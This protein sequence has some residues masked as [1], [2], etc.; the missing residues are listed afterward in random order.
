MEMWGVLKYIFKI[1]YLF[2]V[3]VCV[4][5]SMFSTYKAVEGIRFPRNGITDSCQLIM[6]LGTEPVSCTLSDGTTSPALVV[7]WMLRG[8]SKIVK[9]GRCTWETM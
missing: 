4:F 1:V 5:V 2:I 9:T 3:C 8:L 7:K 6:V